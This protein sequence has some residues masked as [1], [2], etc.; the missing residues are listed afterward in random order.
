MGAERCARGAVAQ[1]R[2][3]APRFTPLFATSDTRLAKWRWRGTKAGGGHVVHGEFLASRREPSS[4]RQ[5]VC[6]GTACPLPWANGTT[7]WRCGEAARRA[8]VVQFECG[9]TFLLPDLRWT[10]FSLYSLPALP[11]VLLQPAPAAEGCLGGG[12][13]LAPNSSGP[14]VQRKAADGTWPGLFFT[15]GCLLNLAGPFAQP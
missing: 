11:L 6:I 4:S 7:H 15:G 14:S 12:G 13:P 8:S 3:F 2:T 1:A 5:S 10:F 9:F